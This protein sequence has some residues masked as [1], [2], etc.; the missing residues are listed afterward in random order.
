MQVLTWTTMLGLTAFISA[1]LCI[2]LTNY[3]KK[4][5]VALGLLFLVVSGIAIMSLFYINAKNVDYPDLGTPAQFGQLGDYFGGL[6]NPIFGFI[7]IILLLQAA[8]QKNTDM[9]RQK[10]VRDLASLNRLAEKNKKHILE[11]SQNEVFFVDGSRPYSFHQLYSRISDESPKEITE[12]KAKVQAW[13]DS[14]TLGDFEKHI[15]KKEEYDFN[16]Q[17][18]KTLF[19]EQ[20]RLIK[21][22]RKIIETEELD[23]VKADLASELVDHVY[24][25]PHFLLVSIKEKDEI[26]KLKS[27]LSSLE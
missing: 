11:Y 26:N 6:L 21:T 13:V 1:V 20:Q 12:I 22:Y 2:F 17:P 3:K 5:F 15:G 7:T 25:F 9:D 19:L 10:N 27:K 16:L 24:T 8:K 14:I 18:I 23:Y 4:D